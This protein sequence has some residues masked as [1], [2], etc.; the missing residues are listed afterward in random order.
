MSMALSAKNK[1]E[2]IDDTI[3]E[4]YSSSTGHVL[5]IQCN[6]MVSSW[7]FNAI[8]PDLAVSVLYTNSAHEIKS[9]LQQ[10]VPSWV[11]LIYTLQLEG[12]Y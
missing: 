6:N 5:W 12:E 8:A 2:F 11:L 3:I 9:D 4:P 10:F 7:L 1:T